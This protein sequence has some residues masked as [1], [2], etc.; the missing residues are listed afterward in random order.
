MVT[1]TEIALSAIKLLTVLLGIVIVYL[2]WKAYRA[3][4]RRSLLWLTAA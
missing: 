2:A 1:T 3:S 4:R